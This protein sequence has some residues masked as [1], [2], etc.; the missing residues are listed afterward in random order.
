LFFL[1]KKAVCFSEELQDA[2]MLQLSIAYGIIG[3]SYHGFIWGTCKP[4]CLGINFRQ[5][6]QEERD[7][8]PPFEFCPEVFD[9]SIERFGGSIC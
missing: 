4:L 2:K 5:P 3:N 9:F 6:K 7:I 8:K 1:N